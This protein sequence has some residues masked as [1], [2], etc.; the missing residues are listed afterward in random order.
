MPYLKREGKP[1]LFYAVD[2]FTNPW[3]KRPTIV[4]QHGYGRSG[5]FWYPWVPILAPHFRVVRPDWRGFGRSL[6]D[7]DPAT[8]LGVDDLLDDLLA[9]IAE[10]GGGP[11]HYCGESLGGTLG[12]LLA[13]RHPEQVSSITA[14]SSP[15]AVPEATRDAL[16]FGYASWSDALRAMGTRAWVAA[17]NGST[18]FPTDTD[19]RLIEWYTDEMG[20]TD[21]DVMIAMG[22]AAVAP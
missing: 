14:I 13:A 9:V 16:R 7:F 6:L 3:E 5:V 15:S 1:T 2:D 4:L 20:K 19:P 21:V 10:V 18:R 8:Q 11:V 22:R 12:M 17:A